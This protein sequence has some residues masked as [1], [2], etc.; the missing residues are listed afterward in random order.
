ML[1][2]KMIKWLPLIVTVGFLGACSETKLVVNTAKIVNSPEDKTYPYK[3]GKPYQVN[4]VWYYP[5]V[6]YNYDETGI[7]SWYGPTFHEKKTA[8]G[9]VYNQ[10]ALTAAHKTLPMPSLVQVTNLENG[11]SIQ[12]RIN[13]RGPFKNNRIIDLSYRAAQL[14]GVDKKGTAPVRVQILEQESRAYAEG[15]GQRD[16]EPGQPVPEA[17]PAG[18]VTAEALP[19]PSGKPVFPPNTQ[20][21][22]NQPYNQADQQPGAQPPVRQVNYTPSPSS[23][24]FE[25]QPL[26]QPNGA[27][28]IKP[29][30]ATNIFIQAGAFLQEA[31]ARSLGS[32]LSTLGRTN[33]QEAWVGNQ[34]YYRV[35]IGPI[36]SVEEADRLLQQVINNGANAK[37]VVE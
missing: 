21:P 20:Q 17:A 32:Q 5:K 4:G 25:Q 24:S 27:V 6:D 16:L 15:R 7:A 8:N 22:G 36:A 23:P 11:R 14:L 10:N 12:V 2:L 18:A 33:I 29:V 28:Q 30:T 35:R 1:P 9:E 31:N 13:D 19:P 3:V 26:P 34:R 37:I